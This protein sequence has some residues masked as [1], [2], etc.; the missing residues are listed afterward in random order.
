MRIFYYKFIYLY[1]FDRFHLK[2][3]E[4]KNQFIFLFIKLYPREIM[5][6]QFIPCLISQN[7]YALYTTTRQNLIS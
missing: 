6:I 4:N 3:N 7:I 1:I 5:I 2:R